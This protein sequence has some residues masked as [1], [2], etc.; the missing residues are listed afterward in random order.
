MLEKIGMSWHSNSERRTLIQKGKEQWQKPMYM[1]IMLISAW[2]IWKERN[3]LLF[4]GINP[5]IESWKQRVKTDLLLL[6]HRTKEKLHSF[7]LDFAENI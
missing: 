3:N 2:N 1:E 7:I 6:V 5:S 4:K